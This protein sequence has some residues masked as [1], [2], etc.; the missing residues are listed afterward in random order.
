M[1]GTCRP[2]RTPT[3]RTGQGTARIPLIGRIASLDTAQRRRHVRMFA[4][5]TGSVPTSSERSRRDLVQLLGPL[6]GRRVIRD[7]NEQRGDFLDQFIRRVGQHG[8]DHPVLPHLVVAVEDWPQVRSE[9]PPDARE[10]R[11]QSAGDRPVVVL[12]HSKS[13]EITGLTPG[14]PSATARSAAATSNLFVG[15]I[16]A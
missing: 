12:V 4:D 6:A 3:A 15:T 11:S 2:V 5:A 1:L 9:R 8:V 10:K 16:P 13:S 14:Q 7:S